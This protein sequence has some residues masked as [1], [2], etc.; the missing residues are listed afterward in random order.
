MILGVRNGDLNT[1]FL[2][3]SYHFV[4]HLHIPYPSPS[5]G[6]QSSLF[7]SRIRFPPPCPCQR[8][9]GGLRTG[10]PKR[11][12]TERHRLVSSAC[13]CTSGLINSHYITAPSF[14]LSSTIFFKL[15]FITTV[16]YITPL[17]A[18]LS[19]RYYS[20]HTL[21]VPSSSSDSSQVP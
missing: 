20:C 4:S 10:R 18:T 12:W 16:V 1:Y 15:Q 14:H 8:D 9:N 6:L 3:V 19:S 21:R 5:F 13:Y 2:V 11:A 7:P 17:F